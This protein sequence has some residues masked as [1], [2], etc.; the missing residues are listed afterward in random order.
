MFFFTMNSGSSMNPYV[1]NQP[2]N[3]F[4]CSISL[5]YLIY[6]KYNHI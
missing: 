1:E 4:F 5:Y 2:M 3:F 6:K